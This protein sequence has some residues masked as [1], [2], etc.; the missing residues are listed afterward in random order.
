M[1]NGNLLL[2]HMSLGMCVIHKCICVV[3]VTDVCVSLAWCQHVL[4]SQDLVTES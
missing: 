1:K 4:Y 3:R 2:L